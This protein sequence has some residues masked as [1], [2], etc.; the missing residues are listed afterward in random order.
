LIYNENIKYAY[1]VVWGQCSE[2]LRATLENCGTHE[3]I[4][5]AGN[6]LG[7]LENIK[8]AAFILQMV[9]HKVCVLHEAKCRFILLFQA[10]NMTV[11]ANL[12]KIKNHVDVTER[13][14]GSAN[15]K[16]LI[17]IALE[18]NATPT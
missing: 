8:D 6:V 5:L 18:G 1:L 15:E 13:C 9:K 14:G 7:L 4:A 2:A 11:Q 10:R 12:E 16:S 3:A 17:A